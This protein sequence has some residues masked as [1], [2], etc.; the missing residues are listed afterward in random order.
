MRTDVMNLLNGVATKNE[1]K[2]ERRRHL[3][4]AA[5][6]KVLF[7]L[8]DEDVDDA[9]Y[10]KYEHLADLDLP[11][12]KTIE[13]VH[14]I[15]TLLCNAE[16]TRAN[17]LAYFSDMMSKSLEAY[18]HEARGILGKGLRR[19][20]E[21]DGLNY[22][23][24]QVDLPDIGSEYRGF[25][26]R[27]DE[28]KKALDVQ[29][30]TIKAL[31]GNFEWPKELD[32][33]ESGGHRLQAKLG[34]FQK[35]WS[36]EDLAKVRVNVTRR[37]K[38]DVPAP[39]LKE[40]APYKGM[41]HIV[42]YA[43]E[44]VVDRQKA[45]Y[46][47]L[48]EEDL[49]ID[50]TVDDMILRI[51]VRLE[52]H[53]PLEYALWST[54]STSM[55][56]FVPIQFWKSVSD[57][58]SYASATKRKKSHMPTD[59]VC[60]V[61][62][63]DDELGSYIKEHAV[64]PIKKSNADGYVIM[65]TGPIYWIPEAK[66]SKHY[67]ELLKQAYDP[68]KK[69]IK[70]SSELAHLHNIPVMTDWVADKFFY[71]TSSGDMS[72]FDMLGS[73]PLDNITI[74]RVFDRP[75]G[76][77]LDRMIGIVARSGFKAKYEMDTVGLVNM[78]DKI[79]WSNLCGE[80]F[81][82]EE[83]LGNQVL[84]AAMHDLG[85]TFRDFNDKMT[86]SVNAEGSITWPNFY[87]LYDQIQTR[88]WFHLVGVY[89]AKRMDYARELAD[90][91]TRNTGSGKEVEPIVHGLPNIPSGALLP[92][93][94]KNKCLLDLD[95][96]NALIGTEPGGGKSLQTV[97]NITSM[98]SRGK[99]SKPLV[100]MPANLIRDWINDVTN[101][102]N[103]Q[104][105]VF[106][107]TLEVWYRWTETLKLNYE[108]IMNLVKSQPK[109]KTIF[110]T[111]Y[112]FIRHGA[113]LAGFDKFEYTFYPKSNLLA[114]ME[115]DY[116]ALDESHRMRNLDSMQTR[117]TISAV[118]MTDYKREFSGTFII[119]DINDRVGQMAVINPA[120]LGSD[121]EDYLDDDG[122]FDMSKMPE[123]NRNISMYAR[124]INN[125][126]RQWSFLLPK[127]REHTYFCELTA[128]QQAFY[129]KIMQEALAEIKNDPKLMKLIESGDEEAQ[130]AIEN[131]M[132][133]YL[134]KPEMFLNAP[135]VSVGRAEYAAMF[136]GLSTTTEADLIS[137]KVHMVDKL[138][139]WHYKGGRHPFN[140][141]DKTEYKAS[142][143]KVMVVS[144][145]KVVS[146]HMARHSRWSN[147]FVRYT[148]GDI[149]ALDAFKN[150]PDVLG[151]FADE[152]SIKEGWNF[153]VASRL[154]RVQSLW[155]PG[156]Q[157]QTMARVLRPDVPD[158]TGKT[159]YGR[160]FI[161][162]DWVVTNNSMEIAKQARMIS[163]ILSKAQA[164][165]S[166]T[167]SF[168]QMIAANK[169]L[170]ANL[171]T[172]SMNINL[173]RD[174]N[175]KDIP[176]LN[177]YYE[178][179]IHFKSWEDR[180]FEQ[181]RTDL[182]KEIS[183][184]LGRPVSKEELGSLAMVK[185]KTQPLK[186][187][188]VG[189]YT[190][191]IKGYAPHD[192][193]NLNLQPLSEANS[194]DDLDDEGNSKESDTVSNLE[195]KGGDIVMTE[196]GPG[197][198]AKMRQG[199]SVVYVV[200]P[201]LSDQAVGLPRSAVF[202]P[203]D[204]AKREALS[205]LL[206]QAGSRGMPTLQK[207]KTGQVINRMNNLPTEQFKSA[208]S[209]VSKLAKVRKAKETK[210]V[211]TEKVPTKPEKAPAKTPRQHETQVK[212][213]V[214]PKPAAKPAAK[215]PA[216]KA[217]KTYE[218]DVWSEL[219]NNQLALYTFQGGD[220]DEL[221]EGRG[222]WPVG[223]YM[224][225]TVT[226]WKGLQNRLDQLKA[227]Y[228]VPSDLQ[229]NI[230]KMIVMLKSNKN[231]V[232]KILPKNTTFLRKFYLDQKR[233]PKGKTEIHPYVII[234]GDEVHLYVNAS[235]TPIARKLT[236][237]TKVQFAGK[238]TLEDPYLLKFVGNKIGAEREIEQLQK[239]GVDIQNMKEL[240]KELRAY[241]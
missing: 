132:Q 69:E 1:A 233:K 29:A 205:H 99:A 62:I 149:S 190:P 238:F 140:P 81:G 83:D 18:A 204:P 9:L 163:R 162:L 198:V 20:F 184:K 175:N 73:R 200:V 194:P 143:N 195:V 65:P 216:S 10:A 220:N 92:H 80:A 157:A 3:Q 172:L 215:T 146:E 189:G 23:R 236:T 74:A 90:S 178:G 40:L 128:N 148:A 112:E 199:S 196:F 109:F 121:L 118:A 123:F 17:R 158:A 226:G 234:S 7:K 47:A 77:M 41:F 13:T 222:W 111:S 237:L 165:E 129:N 27:S 55:A 133:W 239:R 71:T 154:I 230:E 131:R 54:F 66:G 173:L 135:D 181:A 75:V 161:D 36:L 211:V 119:K 38:Y 145:H 2:L 91:I 127:V 159:K 95:P 107:I 28:E 52:I 193:H 98:W 6:E 201:G 120:C 82:D 37:A 21:I 224:H 187:T 144:Y 25:S 60:N 177:K 170:F 214:V 8:D 136:R 43:K 114:N 153:Q 105:R 179:Y 213:K 166:D 11:V 102:S 35:L 151:I 126:R 19:D 209:S 85:N 228:V 141:S 97:E 117:A 137:P 167:F 33:E 22:V 150:D 56:N 212:V 241:K 87:S 104:I 53:L 186:D 207:S 217:P 124:Q 48:T 51:G 134:D 208:E 89:G 185:V 103:G 42:L 229:R 46:R 34:K 139:D 49:N 70:D 16:T 210:K 197:Y 68:D 235:L 72:M 30:A 58:L 138:I 64:R 142:K 206:R 160:A 164:E 57:R 225:S 88:F 100:I 84:S 203:T 94:Y 231:R 182:Q 61:S 24:L 130:K 113:Y 155:N 168:N 223:S 202:Y 227:K 106:P 147:R 32:P 115:F 219:I 76:Q 192:L 176:L 96:L 79:T 110:V 31:L 116:A 63:A 45:Y 15:S 93:Q 191:W 12:N 232:E 180:E 218:Y 44:A 59:R 67:T 78:A 183:E 240:T 156:D 152:A 101:F 50:H 14:Y 169:E 86:K 188:S 125:P 174:F 5:G 171:P 108:Q 221:F 122:D 4:L 26:D 39:D